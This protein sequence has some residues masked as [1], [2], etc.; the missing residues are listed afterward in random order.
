M[1]RVLS[2]FVSRLFVAIVLIAA[3][4]I[5]I[6]MAVWALYTNFYYFYF[7][8]LVISIV[9]VIWII[10]KSDNPSYKIAWIILILI[11]PVFGGLFY[12]LFGN[13]RIPIKRKRQ[14]AEIEKH[15][16]PYV[17]HNTWELAQLRHEDD[18]GYRQANYLARKGRAPVCLSTETDF[19]TPGEV[20]FERLI[21]ELEKA[22]RYIFMEY[23]IVQK[24]VLLD[25]VL[26]ILERKAA[27]G[28]EV[29]FMY[30]DMG[31]ISTVPSS[32]AKQL[33]ARGLKAVKFNPMTP[34]IHAFQN[35]RDHRK[36]TVID[37][38]V[39]FTGGVNLADEYVNLKERFGYWKDSALMLKGDAVWPILLTFLE[40][41]DM[42][43]KVEKED[44]TR[45]FPDPEEVARYHEDGYVVPY[46]D[47][48]LDYETVGENV[49]R[50]LI[51]KATEYVFIETPYFIV[52]NEMIT[53]IELAAK[54][55]V[56]V[57]I[58]V[59]HIPDKHIVFLLTQA[60]Y[61]QLIQAGAHVYEY[62]PGFIHT[63]A[64]VADNLYASVG[65]VNFDYRS[66]YL[67][68]ECGVWMY[69][70]KAVHQVRNDFLETLSY[71]QEITAE[72]MAERSAFKRLLQAI[73][74]V[75]APLL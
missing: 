40:N 34:P 71:C 49:Y 60:H 26:E 64:C 35:N 70:S 32:F 30:D 73:F 16:A 8:F 47:D 43:A 59:P 53:S 42:A 69:R 39:A 2:F 21:E 3:Q 51:D 29:R 22:Q 75:F 1:R 56:D 68:F 58:I 66:F 17:P 44:M 12:V 31:S 67:H 52:D 33:R 27:E 74:R 4:I 61:P 41:W 13:H 28:V 18:A 48:P 46:E 15:L 38:I 54:A 55:G 20:H 10:S 25:K 14:R 45:Y 72:Q 50:N 57:R 5:L 65:T 62:T 23:F 11:F 24:G 19:Q 6:G 36:I 37:G 7:V 9:A 63:K